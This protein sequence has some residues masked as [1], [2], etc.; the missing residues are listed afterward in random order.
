MS[1]LPLVN[2]WKIRSTI[3]HLAVLNIKMR[4]KNTYL[5]FLWAALEPL[6]YFIVLYVVFNSIRDRGEDFAIYLI[7]GVMLYHIFSRGTSGGIGSLTS[8][9]SILKS[10]NIRKEIFPVV[11]TVAIGLLAF[12]DAGVFFGL[13]PIFQF[14]PSWTIIFLP[15]PIFLLLILILGLSYLLSI[16]TIYVRDIQHLW[17]IFVHALI[18][19]SPIFWYLDEVEEDSIL[20]AIQKINPLGQ[21]IEISHKLV[22]WGEIPSFQ[23]WM[24][25]SAFVF[26]I[27]AIGY[28][29]FQKYQIK[30]V[31]EL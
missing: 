15:I 27:F 14:T 25:T 30:T 1:F 20:L 10:L 19:I 2:L 4:F 31:E 24:Y 7:T 11:A 12:V 5:G 13:M 23:E 16:V 17:I 28:T 3:F 6:L 9:S 8:N 29:V 18:F 26:A 22:V 21:L